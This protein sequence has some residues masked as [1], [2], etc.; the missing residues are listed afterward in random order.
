MA[1]INNTY[2]THYSSVEEMIGDVSIIH[3]VGKKD[4]PWVYKTALMRSYWDFC[5]E[6]M[7]YVGNLNLKDVDE[8]KRRRLDSL[9]W[10]VKNTGVTGLISFVLYSLRNRNK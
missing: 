5:F 8:E 6:K 3:Y 1:D 9:V 4:K 10:I 7:G 2:A